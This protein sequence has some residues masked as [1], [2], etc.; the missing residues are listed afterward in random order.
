MGT[1]YDNIDFDERRNLL[2]LK[3]MVAWVKVRFATALK[4][5]Y[6]KH[7]V[8]I[9]QQLHAIEQISKVAL[10][11][12]DDAWLIEQN[13]LL[14]SIVTRMFLHEILPDDMFLKFGDSRFNANRKA[15]IVDISLYPVT[16]SMAVAEVAPSAM[17]IVKREDIVKSF[18]ERQTYIADKEVDIIP[19]LKSKVNDLLTKKEQDSIKEYFDTY[20]NDPDVLESKARIVEMKTIEDNNL[21]SVLR[22][23]NSQGK[24]T[25]LLKLA[26]SIFTIVKSTYS[27]SPQKVSRIMFEGKSPSIVPDYS[28]LFE[29]D[30][31]I[32]LNEIK[33]ILDQ[34][35]DSQLKIKVS[36][37]RIL[38]TT[39]SG[40]DPDNKEQMDSIN[41][42]KFLSQ[43]GLDHIFETYVGPLASIDDVNRIMDKYLQQRYQR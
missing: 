9:L 26:V 28:M 11:A 35:V 36:G 32:D 41:C 20:K 3:A 37:N 29:I 31:D 38:F 27:T 13:S 4:I 23:I 10:I 33:A 24:R 15:S 42:T 14:Y 5:K 30:F 43:K 12:D 39:L 22:A 6:S 1:V 17:W 40:M 7:E 8:E 21:K 25:E 34:V 2:L 18:T 16:L 19:L